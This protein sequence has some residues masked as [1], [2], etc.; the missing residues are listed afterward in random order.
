MTNVTYTHTCTVGSMNLLL[1][2]IF[3]LHGELIKF[4]SD[5]VRSARACVP[6]CINTIWHRRHVC[7]LFFTGEVPVKVLPA[8]LHD[9]A[10]FATELALV[11]WPWVAA[12]SL[13]TTT[14]VSSAMTAATTTSSKTATPIT[15]HCNIHIHVLQWVLGFEMS[16]SIQHL[17]I[18]ITHGR[19]HEFGTDGFHHGIEL[20][21]QARQYVGHDV[22]FFKLLTCIGHF[23]GVAL[24]ESE[25]H[26][27][28]LI[29][30]LAH[31]WQLPTQMN[32]PCPW[33][34][35]VHLLQLLPNIGRCF[36]ISD[37]PE[38]LLG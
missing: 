7:H 35:W 32:H 9:V 30:S 28:C 31:R 6:I 21:I 16:L 19:G 11:M 5:V 12:S 27:T 38:H 3:L 17:S 1:A 29:F 24:H 23:I 18:Q 10:K 34:G 13:M 2:T 8:A 26:C 4:T 37:L 33:L 14:I 25:I 36:L 20:C 22:F 15:A